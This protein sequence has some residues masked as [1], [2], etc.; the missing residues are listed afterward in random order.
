M[1]IFIYFFQVPNLPKTFTMDP[2]LSS[3]ENEPLP[4]SIL[5]KLLELL[6]VK[7]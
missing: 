7:M 5:F 4:G 6:R 2:P 3:K 1:N